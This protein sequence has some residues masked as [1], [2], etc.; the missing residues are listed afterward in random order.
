V[1]E[2][3]PRLG[4]TICART[5]K[6]AAFECD[7]FYSKTD[8]R[9]SVSISAS[10]ARRDEAALADLDAVYA[11]PARTAPTSVCRDGW[12][13]ADYTTAR[14]RHGSSAAVVVRHAAH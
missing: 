11:R 3:A 4:R 9:R 6:F 2:A 7:G 8:S 1:F 12:N 13:A 10:A 14:A 5:R